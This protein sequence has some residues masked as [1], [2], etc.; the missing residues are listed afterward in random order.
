MSSC[1]QFL[2]SNILR[3]GF[4]LKISLNSVCRT[5]FWWLHLCL[6]RWA[7]RNNSKPGIPS[8]KAEGCGDDGARVTGGGDKR[9]IECWTLVSTPGYA[10]SEITR[11]P[12]QNTKTGAFIPQSNDYL[13]VEPGPALLEA[14][15]VKTFFIASSLFCTSCRIVASTMH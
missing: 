15:K 13:N 5:H 8:S 3:Q 4:L 14:F 9:G 10:A 12:M 1:Y 7:A 11:V 6:Y 2:L